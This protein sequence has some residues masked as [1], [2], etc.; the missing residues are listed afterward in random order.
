MSEQIP[1]AS[2]MLPRAGLKPNTIEVRVT[3]LNTIFGNT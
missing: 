2:Q 1:S 3:L